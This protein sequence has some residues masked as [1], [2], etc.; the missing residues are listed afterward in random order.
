MIIIKNDNYKNQDIN[1]RLNDIMY[2]F[3]KFYI[4]LNAISI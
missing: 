4:H 2:K 1:R 3:T